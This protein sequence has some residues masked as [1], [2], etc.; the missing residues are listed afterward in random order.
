MANKKIKKKNMKMNNLLHPQ[1]VCSSVYFFKQKR[2]KSEKINN[3]V[4][5]I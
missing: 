3:T 4:H 1:N 2:C 5:V